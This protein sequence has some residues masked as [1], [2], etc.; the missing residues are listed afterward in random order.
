[1]KTLR[2]SV[3][4]IAYEE[5]APADPTGTPV[6]LVHGFPDDARSW[7]PVAEALAARGRRVV[8]PYLRGFGPTRFLDDATPR[9]GQVGALTQDLL[10]LLDG[11]GLDR[12]VLAGQDWGARAVQGVAAVAPD[13]VERLV[14]LGGYALSWDQGGQ[15]SYPQLHALWY[16]FLLRAG[17]GEGILRMDPAGFNRYLWRVWSPTWGPEAAVDEAFAAMAPSLANPDFADVVLAGYRDEPLDDHYAELEARLAEG[18]AITVPTVV[19]YGADDG[20]EPEGPDA[21]GD[22]KRFTAL[23]EARTVQDAGHF[24]HRERPDAVLAALSQK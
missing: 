14:S 16:Q 9:S 1:M 18:P 5:W 23:I 22:A 19:L 12:A 11:L 7:A 13:R 2:T 8:A 15:P 17:W 21:E 20:L 3:L 10:D 6:V 4:D 24:L